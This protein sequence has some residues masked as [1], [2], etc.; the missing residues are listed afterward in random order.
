MKV[1]VPE[2]FGSFSLGNF[3]FGFW[4]G[5]FGAQVF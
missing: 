1:V 3:Q 2:L 5:D 4:L